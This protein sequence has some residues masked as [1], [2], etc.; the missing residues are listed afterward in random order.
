MIVV[1]DLEKKYGRNTALDGVSLEVQSG[2]LFAYLG[3]NGAGK[4]T[5][6]RILTG[7]TRPGGGQARLAGFDIGHQAQEARK[8]CGV[9][10]QTV[11][12]D[13]ELSVAQNLDIHGRLFGMSRIDRRTRAG[14]LLD[15]VGLADRTASQ[16][17][18]LSGGMRRRLMMARALM[19]G[20]RILFLDEPT[21]GLD[22]AI[23]RRIWSLIRRINRDGTTVFLTTHYMEE[24]EFLARRVAFLDRGRIVALDEPQNLMVRLGDWAVDVLEGQELKTTCF[25]SR[26]RAQEHLR[27]A[28]GGGTL[29]RVNLE[30][31]FLAM[32]G[33]RI[34]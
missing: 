8:Q 30:D 24:A 15:Y 32:T 5:T 22:P 7:L 11:N 34:D 16:V 27:Q 19:H 14:E 3:P 33:R 6:I 29:R 20:P 9:A 17:K 12:L 10:G 2:E 21:A 25:T 4:T 23:R 26:Q 31:A 18:T 13:S 28:E 1:R